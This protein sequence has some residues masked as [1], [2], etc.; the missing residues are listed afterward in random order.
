MQTSRV[1]PGQGVLMTLYDVWLHE[2]FV[3]GLYK[4]LS[5][6]WIKGP[7]AVGISF[8]TYEHVLPH[9]KYY[10]SRLTA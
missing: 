5:M 7:M 3:H 2:G 9:M 10:M 1:P 4:G 6:N 8:T